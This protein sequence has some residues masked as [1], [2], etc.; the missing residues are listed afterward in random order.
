LTYFSWFDNNAYQEVPTGV[1]APEVK[2]EVTVSFREGEAIVKSAQLIIGINVFD[3][4][5]QKLKQLYP[6]SQEVNISLVNYPSGLYLIQIVGEKG[7]VTKKI[8][9]N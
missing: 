7:V 2:S 5:G 4:Q 8:I 9:K 1:S 6:E 3:L